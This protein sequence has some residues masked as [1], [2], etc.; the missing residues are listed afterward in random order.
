MFGRPVLSQDD[1]IVAPAENGFHASRRAEPM[2][3]FFG[4][5]ETDARAKLSAALARWDA[6]RQGIAEHKAAGTW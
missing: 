1:V 6:L 3:Q 2:R 5:T 4:R